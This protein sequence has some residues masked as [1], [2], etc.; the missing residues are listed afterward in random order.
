M[1]D[2][3]AR[4]YMPD[5]GRWGV[6][7]M[8]NA[9]T[10]DSYG[11]ANNNPVFFNDPTGMIG[12]DP[13][14]E[15][16]EIT[17]EEVQLVHVNKIKVP[18]VKEL[19]MPY[20]NRYVMAE[21]SAAY[22]KMYDEQLRKQMQ[23]GQ[24]RSIVRNNGSAMMMSGDVLGLSDLLGIL[25]S[26]VET[27]NRYAMMGIPLIA[28]LATK[29][30]AA[31]GVIEAD[32]YVGVRAASQYLQTAGVPRIIRKEIL[33]SFQIETIALKTADDATFG[34]R[35]YGGT[36]KESGRYLFPT[37]SETTTRTGLALPSSWGNTMEKISQ[38]QV[39]PGTQYI[40]GRAASQGGVYSGGNFQMY[41]NDVTNL[42]K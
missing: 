7:D 41:I 14:K 17:I 25:L 9:F 18:S 29:G 36:A 4:F 27:K 11:Y 34:L 5:I 35:F 20:F 33:E 32:S 28:I 40:Y 6:V 22:A 38:F 19:N 13:K 21:P 39:A 26:K 24:M 2:Y 23:E 15:A 31:P 37:F 42:I 3:G 16:R 12:E 10:L 1:Y 30:K 8:L